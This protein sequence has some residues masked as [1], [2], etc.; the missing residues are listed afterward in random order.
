VT[1]GDLQKYLRNLADAIGAAK[2]SAK[3]LEEAAAALT[4][5]AK[6]KIDAFA[7]FLQ[8]AEVKYRTTGELPDGKPPKPPKPEKPTAAAL[9]ALIEDFKTRLGRGET[10]ARSAVMEAVSKFEALKK[11]EL[12]SAVKGLGYQTKPKTKPDAI[13]VIVDNVLAASTAAARVEV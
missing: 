11:T 9:A 13:N 2:G 1:V 8:L 6:Y 3:E 10:I 5:F 7:K 12:E 4:P